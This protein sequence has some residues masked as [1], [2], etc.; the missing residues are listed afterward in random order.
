MT[1]K[2]QHAPSWSWM[3]PGTRMITD[4]GQEKISSGYSALT[5]LSIV[6]RGEHVDHLH[7]FRAGYAFG[8]AL[9]RGE[10]G[11]ITLHDIDVECTR[12]GRAAMSWREGFALRDD[13]AVRPS[14]AKPVERATAALDEAA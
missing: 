1:F 2:S 9:A 3:C 11:L 5:N 8:N 4:K 13:T 7:A 12:Y 6:S 14:A 10:L